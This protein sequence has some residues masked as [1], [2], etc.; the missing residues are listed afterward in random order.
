MTTKLSNIDQKTLKIVNTYSLED[1]RVIVCE[2][3]NS[4]GLTY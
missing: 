4:K 3:L 2:F 1:I